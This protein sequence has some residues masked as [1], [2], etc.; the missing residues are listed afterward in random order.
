MSARSRHSTTETVLMKV[1]PA[2][3]VL[4]LAL[5]IMSAVRLAVHRVGHQ[6]GC[7]HQQV[8]SQTQ[9]ADCTQDR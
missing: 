8:A 7:L 9:T 3:M 4:V 2:I 1:V 6:L 5:I